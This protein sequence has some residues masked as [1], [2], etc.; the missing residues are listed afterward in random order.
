MRKVPS[1]S[2]L[3]TADTEGKTYADPKKRDQM[4]FA[5]YHQSGG[6]FGFETPSSENWPQPHVEAPFAHIAIQQSKASFIVMADK[7][8]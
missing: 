3:L 7:G 5:I 4:A 2:S 6:Q 8:Q 1:D